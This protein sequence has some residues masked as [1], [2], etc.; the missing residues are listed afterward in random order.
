MIFRSFMLVLQALLLRVYWQKETC[1]FLQLEA[2]VRVAAELR[3]SR[4]SYPA[5]IVE[6]SAGVGSNAKSRDT[7]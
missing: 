7:L 5:D 3:C 6:A 1:V 2:T 4:I